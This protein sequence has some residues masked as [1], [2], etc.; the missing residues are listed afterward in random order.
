[1]QLNLGRAGWFLPLSP[2]SKQK[3]LNT[4]TKA[5]KKRQTLRKRQLRTALNHSGNHC[6]SCDEHTCLS[7]CCTKAAAECNK[8][9]NR[10][11]FS[12]IRCRYGCNHTKHSWCM[13]NVQQLYHR[14]L[15]C[16]S[17]PSECIS[18]ALEQKDLI[19]SYT[20]RKL[21]TKNENFG[22]TCKSITAFPSLRFDQNLWRY[23]TKKQRRKFNYKLLFD[24]DCAFFNGKLTSTMF[25]GEHVRKLLCWTARQKYLICWEI[26]VYKAHSCVAKGSF[27]DTSKEDLEKRQDSDSVI[28]SQS[29]L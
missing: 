15:F 7:P 17:A 19:Q 20:Q 6:S 22:F 24:R 14:H 12:S 13:G 29:F 4:K 11:P 16:S 26:R 5:K 27:T 21:K 28:F 9:Y 2:R 3:Q 1:M 23:E 8:G 10:Q 18:A 25:S